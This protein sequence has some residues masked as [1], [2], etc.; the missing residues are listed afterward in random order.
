MTETSPKSIVIELLSD[1]TFSRGVGTAGAVDVEV[2]HDEFGIPFINGKTVRGLLRDSWLSMRMRDR[3]PGL[4]YA[5]AR[6]FGPTARFLDDDV[7]ILRIGDAGLQEDV[8][9]WLLAA[10]TRSSETDRM[11]PQEILAACTDI[12]R[13]TA[14][15]C[16]TGAPARD[17]LRSTRVVLRETVFVAPL[18]WRSGADVTNHD[19]AV[20]AMAALATRHGGLGRNRGRGFL[21][22]TLDG[23]LAETRERAT[24]GLQEA[25]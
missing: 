7:C 14:E 21:K 13:Q 5:E 10:A 2:E 18:S 15:D 25:E 19:L 4:Q 16:F 24:S 11:P 8:R 3:F 1:A 9:N 20:L 12:R 17:T 23:D 22:I 6:V